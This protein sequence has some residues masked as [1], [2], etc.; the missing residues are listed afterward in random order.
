MVNLAHQKRHCDTMDLD[1]DFVVSSLQDHF[2][3]VCTEL[4]TEPFLS[5]CGHHV[6]HKCH[7]HIMATRKSPTLLEPPVST[8]TYSE[9]SM[10]SRFAAST[11]RQSVSG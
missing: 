1:F 7:K 3:P 4:L 10:T 6:C 2:C 8:N 9:R 5:N 11:T